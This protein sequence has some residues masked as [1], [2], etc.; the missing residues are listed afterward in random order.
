MTYRA[1]AIGLVVLTS[2]ACGG[3]GL[4]TGFGAAAPMPIGTTA[5][6][7]VCPPDAMRSG[8]VSGGARATLLAL[9]PDDAFASPELERKLPLTGKV[10]TEGELTVTDGC[11]YGGDWVADNGDSYYFYKA[12][13]KPE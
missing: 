13:F 1:A 12:A 6:T 3:A 9:H 2:L 7:T 10:P 4:D 5:G 11:W 8:D